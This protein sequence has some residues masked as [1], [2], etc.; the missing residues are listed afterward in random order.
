MGLCVV[1]KREI[2]E[3]L[4]L[5]DSL[6]NSSKSQHRKALAI[7]FYTFST[8]DLLVL[9]ISNARQFNSVIEC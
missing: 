1:L 5:L 6:I 2:L 9:L 7:H 3:V 8:T 4:F